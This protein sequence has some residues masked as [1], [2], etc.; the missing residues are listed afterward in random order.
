MLLFALCFEP[1]LIEYALSFGCCQARNV[2]S[3][4]RALQSPQRTEIPNKMPKNPEQAALSQQ[5][6]WS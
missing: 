5:R 1:W 2:L 3:E 6:L 4:S